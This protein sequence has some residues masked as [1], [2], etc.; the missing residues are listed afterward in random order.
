M[1]LRR[2]VE[3]DS[4]FRSEGVEQRCTIALADLTDFDG[5][6]RVLNEHE[7]GE[8]FH[9]GAQTIVGTANRSPLGTWEANVRGT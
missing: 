3:P 6:L 8:V 2:D 4:R 5:L 1:A 7:V 9:L